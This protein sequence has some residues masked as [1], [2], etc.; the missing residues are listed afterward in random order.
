[1]PGHVLKKY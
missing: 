1:V